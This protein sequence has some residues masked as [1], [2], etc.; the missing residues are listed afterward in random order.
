MFNNYLRIA[1]RNLLRHKAFSFIN[2]IGL[3]IG[4]TC[5]LLIARYVQHELSYDNFHAKA[6]RIVRVTMEYG[7]NG[8]VGKA[9]VTGTKVAPAF[10]RAFPEVEKGVRMIRRSVVVR[11]G[12]K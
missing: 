3:A 8:E 9:A 2:I 10:G 5:C 11:Y 1:L 4:L 7:G 12:E 6:D